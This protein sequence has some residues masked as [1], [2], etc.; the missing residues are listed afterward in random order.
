MLRDLNSQT[1]TFTNHAEFFA[2]T[3]WQHLE[4]DVDDFINKHNADNKGALW[5]STAKSEI[6]FKSKQIYS[7]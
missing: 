4:G 3:S 6:L 2:T 1:R 5:K 7:K